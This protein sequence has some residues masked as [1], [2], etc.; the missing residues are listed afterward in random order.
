[1]LAKLRDA[2]VPSY[3]EARSTSSADA[4]AVKCS[5]PWVKTPG[6]TIVVSI[7]SDATSQAVDSA[8]PS[9]AALAAV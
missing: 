9:K 1:M 4:A 7:P 5:V 8:K 2:A 3:S 6:W